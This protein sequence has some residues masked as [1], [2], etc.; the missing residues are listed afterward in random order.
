VK[1]GFG[2]EPGV[3]FR[4]GLGGITGTR[5]FAK[6]SDIIVKPAD[7]TKVSDAIVRVFIDTGDRHQ[8]AQGADEICHRR[9]RDGEV[10]RPDRRENGPCLHPRAGGS[11]GARPAFDRHGAYRR[12]QARSRRD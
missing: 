7:A 10:L 12:S 2:V 5:I 4:L 3:W 9:H 8:P 6:Y 1:D 11:H